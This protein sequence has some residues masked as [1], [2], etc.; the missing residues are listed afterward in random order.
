MLR[1]SFI[2]FIIS[3]SITSLAFAGSKINMKEGKW[4]VTTKMEM[5][6]MPM[7]MPPVTN[8]QCLTK[9]DFIPQ[10]SQ[11]GQECKITDQK[12]SKNTVTWTVKCKGQGIESKGTGK[13][14]YNGSSFKG[15]IKVSTIQP[16]MEMTTHVSGRRIGNCK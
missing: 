2:I 12:I 3:F 4:E 10:S 5:Q 6:G 15:I 7:N 11:A 9:K 1:K 8:T 16:K 14:T 13:I